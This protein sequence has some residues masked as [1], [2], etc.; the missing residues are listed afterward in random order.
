MEKIL[1]KL[2]LGGKYSHCI[3]MELYFQ[4]VPLNIKKENNNSYVEVVKLALDADFKKLLAEDIK[5]LLLSIESEDDRNE[6]IKKVNRELKYNLQ[7]S[8]DFNVEFDE[9]SRAI[10]FKVINIIYVASINKEKC[11]TILE[12]EVM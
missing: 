3:V 6:F 9:D 12:L 4:N 1:C 8:E 5:R 2:F 11:G 7:I 10:P